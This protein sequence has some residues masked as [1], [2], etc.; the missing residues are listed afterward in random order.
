MQSL[1]FLTYFF[2]KSSVEEKPLV[3]EGLRPSPPKIL[4]FFD[5]FKIFFNVSVLSVGIAKILLKRLNALLRY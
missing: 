5:N 2:F 4:D 1:V 3:K